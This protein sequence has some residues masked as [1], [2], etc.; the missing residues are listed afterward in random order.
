MWREINY[1]RRVL[2]WKKKET[3]QRKKLLKVVGGNDAEG[4]FRVFFVL[5]S[6]CS[7]PRRLFY[8]R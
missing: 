1:P 6:L 2:F 7:P 3:K 4:R 5:F 8:Q